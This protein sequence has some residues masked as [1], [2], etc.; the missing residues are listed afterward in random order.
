M[1]ELHPELYFNLE[2]PK[3]KW[4]NSEFPRNKRSNSATLI[5]H[6]IKQQQIN[7]EIFFYIYMI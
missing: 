3:F 7:S 4:Q 5:Y 2:I 1:I 6:V